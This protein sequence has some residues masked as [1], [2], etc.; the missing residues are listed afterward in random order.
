MANTYV[1]YTATAGQTDFA[2]SFPYLEDS[3]VVVEVEG[4]NQTLT[5]NYTIETAPAQKIVLSSPTTAIAGGEL[6]RVKRVSAPDENLVDFVNGSVLTETELD[7]AYLH[8]RYLAEEAYDGV[9]S[10]LKELEG[11]TN[12]NANNKQIKNLADGTLATDAVNKQYVDTQIAL[13]DTNLAGFNKSTHTGNAIDNVFTLSFTPQT[14]DAKAYI[15]S[16]DGLVQVPDTDYTIDATAITFNTIP[17]NSAEI[18]VVATAAASVAAA[19][20]I[21]VTA[22]GSTIARGLADRFGDALNVLDFIPSNLHASIINGTNTTD[23]SPYFQAAI[24]ASNNVTIP[25]GTYYLDSSVTF[26]E[27]RS[28]ILKGGG[29]GSTILKGRSGINLLTFAG[30]AVESVEVSGIT[31]DGEFDRTGITRPYFDNGSG[32]PKKAHRAFSYTIESAADIYFHSCEFLNFYEL[33]FVVYDNRGSVEFSNNRVYKCKDVGFVNCAKVTVRNNRIYWSHDNA[34]SVSR[35]NRNATITDNFIFSPEF[36][37]IACYGFPVLGVDED[38]PDGF[39][40]SNNIILMSGQYNISNARAAKNGSLIGNKLSYGGCYADADAYTSTGS[41]TG[42]S[43]TL[44]VASNDINGLQNGDKLVAIPKVTES[45]IFF[46]EVS[47]GGGTTTLTLDRN[48]E[49]DFTD[50]DIYIIAHNTSGGAYIVSG[51]TDG[52]DRYAENI[53]FSSNIIEGAAKTAL[54]LGTN[55]GAVKWINVKNNTIDLHKENFDPNT[56]AITINDVSTSYRTSFVSVQSNSIRLNGTLNTKGISYVPVDTGPGSMCLAEGNFISGVGR[57]GND[58]IFPDKY[59]PSNF[60]SSNA[61]SLDASSNQVTNRANITVS[62]STL[63]ATHYYNRCDSASP[64]NVTDLAHTY[65]GDEYPEI[66]IENSGTNAITLVHDT[67]KIRNTSG[68]NVVLGRFQTAR[69]LRVTPTIWQ[70]V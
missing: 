30:P 31:F 43:T 5:T 54:T 50:A 38:G 61:R 18:C 68:A 44:T 36:T 17:A 3:H 20:G 2:F 14:T 6:V 53:T 1:D 45:D 58:V 35:G 42:G 15:V 23:L 65:A 63:T 22:T 66:I 56:I 52:T 62:T 57:V 39:V 32:S 64:I 48:A 70:Q 41:M 7:R 28:T 33:P 27:N 8:N 9:N 37:G 47:S 24:N 25:L 55:T 21:Q 67:N 4:V 19:G 10:G 40:I 11:S 13:T 16:I 29:V 69:Y 60:D 51:T 12:F 49:N 26:P 59:N 46:A 34:I